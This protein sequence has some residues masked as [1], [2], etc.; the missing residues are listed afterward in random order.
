[1]GWSGSGIGEDKKS[2]ISTIIVLFEIYK[3]FSAGNMEMAI[4]MTS[5]TR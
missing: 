1:M 5:I 2:V 3:D 4:G